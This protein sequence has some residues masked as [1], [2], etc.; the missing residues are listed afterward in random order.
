MVRIWARLGST[1]EKN[2]GVDS[3]EKENRMRRRRSRR[4]R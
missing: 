3:K 1:V 4:R 2:F